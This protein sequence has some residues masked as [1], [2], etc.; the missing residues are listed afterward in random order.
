M[1]VVLALL[2]ATLGL[3]ALAWSAKQLVI[4]ASRISLTLRVSPV[5]VGVVVIGLGTS[6][7]ELFVSGLAAHRGELDLAVGGVVGSNLANL[8]LVLGVAALIVPVRTTVSVILR[9]APL[10]AALTIG[11]AF[12]IQTGLSRIEGAL[13]LAG[14]VVALTVIIAGARGPSDPLAAEVTEFMGEDAAAERRR[15]RLRAEG[16]RVVVGLVGLI[17]GA[18]AL[19]SGAGG[20]AEELGLSEGFIGLTLVALGTSL[21]ELVTAVQAARRRETDLVVGNLLGS[22]LFNSGAVAGAAGLVGPGALTDPGLT[23]VAALLMAAAALLG[24]MML[25]TGRRVVRG[26]GIVLIGAYLIALPFMA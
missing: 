19:V 25:G 18:Q 10:A 12:A 13:L 6:A 5:L 8:T 16:A 2:V 17:A 4:G 20:V 22:N 1:E 15:H 21:P 3:A 24:W 14:F 7:P 9:E 11:V 26:E 23:V